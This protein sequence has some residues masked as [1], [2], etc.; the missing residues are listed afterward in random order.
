M[1]CVLGADVLPLA[2]HGI[3]LRDDRSLLYFICNAACTGAPLCMHYLI[4]TVVTLHVSLHYCIFVWGG[5]GGV[6]GGVWMCGREVR[7]F[8]ISLLHMYVY[9]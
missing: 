3:L 8:F 1:S 7:I 2:H 4:T 5:G 6:G 9:I